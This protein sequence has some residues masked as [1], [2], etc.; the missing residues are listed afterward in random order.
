MNDKSALFPVLKKHIRIRI[1]K[2]RYIVS[3]LRAGDAVLASKEEFLFLSLCT[4][5]HSLEEIMQIYKGVFGITGEEAEKHF[6]VM[7]SKYS[8][9]MEYCR[10]KQKERQTLNIGNYKSNCNQWQF[11]PERDEN[12]SKLT[13]VLT[14]ACNH[15]CNYCFK[16]CSAQRDKEVAC[17]KWK[18]VIEEAQRIGV[19][20]ITFSGGEPFLYPGLL[21]LI[22]LCES[23]GIY[24][25]IS[26]NG[27]FLDEAVIQKLYRAGA[28]YIHLSLPAV[29]DGLYNEITGSVHDLE[30]VKKAVRLL[31]EHGFYIRVKMV[32]MPGNIEEA[33]KLIDFCAKENV[34]FVHL[35]PFI[36]TEKGRGG[37]ELIPSEDSLIQIRNLCIE[38]GKQYEKTVIGEP[39]ISSLCWEGPRNI[40]KCGGIKDSLTILSNG[41]ITFCEALGSNPDFILGN[42][43]ESSIEEIWNSDKPDKI[44]EPDY[45]KL[46]ESC[47]KCEYLGWCKTGCFVYSILQSGNPWSVDPR[48]FRASCSH[49][50]FS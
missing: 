4:G 13:V 23:K 48:C 45:E 6:K 2:G 50:I 26:T 11:A 44:T 41:N 27:T 39:P 19:Q 47:R 18:E 5:S 33:E 30:K 15:K 24:T 29:T 31:K 21:S 28:E 14:E 35:A 1:S 8:E 43:Y 42:V 22:E 37:R 9:E 10:E 12:P 25:K 17:E 3:N 40:S 49:N 20:E 7:T 16:G 36:L 38:K 46:D 34:D 32:L